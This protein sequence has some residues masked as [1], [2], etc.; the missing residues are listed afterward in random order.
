[1][2]RTA[3]WKETEREVARRLGGQRVPVSGRGRGDQPDVQHDVYSIEVKHRKTL[4]G[5]LH[6]AMA[7]AIA[8][9]RGSQ[10]PLVILH[11]TGRPHSENFV[12]IRLG[13]WCDLCGSLRRESDAS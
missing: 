1:V 8:A 12:A 9:Q 13:D 7:Q 3:Q 2:S 11:Q 10:I 4:P 6:R 5:W